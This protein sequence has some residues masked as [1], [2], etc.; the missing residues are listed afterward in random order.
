MEAINKPMETSRVRFEEKTD[1]TAAHIAANT[2]KGNDPEG[3][4]M[5][6]AS[7]T[8]MPAVQ[9]SALAD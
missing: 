3:E 2:S 7:T 9:A 5:A 8:S 1:G 4:M 6:G